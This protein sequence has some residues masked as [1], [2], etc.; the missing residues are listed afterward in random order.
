M[1][2]EHV[3][4]GPI[5]DA[6]MAWQKA[7]ARA[8]VAES[9]I[10]KHLS[11]R[12][13]D[14]GRGSQDTLRMFV[15]IRAGHARGSLTFGD[16]ESGWAAVAECLESVLAEDLEGNLISAVRAARAEADRLRQ[17]LLRLTMRQ[18]AGDDAPTPHPEQSPADA[19]G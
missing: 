5:E 12:E 16:G 17:E 7:D 18:I 4:M 15:S 10:Q 8:A 6:F 13:A 11:I 14:R 9:A 1:A 2:F 19:R 3:E